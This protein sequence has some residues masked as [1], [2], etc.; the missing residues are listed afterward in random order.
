MTLH[1]S[2]NQRYWQILLTLLLIPSL[3]LLSSC[4]VLMHGPNQMIPV[5]SAPQGAEV[6]V[7]GEHMGITPMQVDLSRASVHTI[8]LKLGDLEREVLITNVPEGGSIALDIAPA[9]LGGAGLISVLAS[10]SEDD[11]GLKGIALAITIPI[12]LAS[13]TPLVVDAST[14]AW[15]ELSPGEVFVDFEQPVEAE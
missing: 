11:F 9:A 2:K 8:T 14:G 4:A 5:A 15:Y 6:Y 10:P 7:D 12:F 3:V 13:L 1:S